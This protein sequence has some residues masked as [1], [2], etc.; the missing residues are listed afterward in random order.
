MSTNLKPGRRLLLTLLAILFPTG[1][2]R[3]DDWPQWL[4]SKR[5]GSTREK[6]AAWDANS[7]PKQLWKAAVG[8]GYSSPVAAGG[9]VFVHARGTDV[10]KEEE[11]LTAFD[12]ATG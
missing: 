7:P 12:A 8:N 2:C 3:A 10:A 1:W 11:V 4:G 5:D 9:K 6:V